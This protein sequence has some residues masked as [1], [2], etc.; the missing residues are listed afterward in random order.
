V[1]PIER[2]V[3][4]S[5]P[6]FINIASFVP[7]KN[8][9]FLVDIFYEY[10]KRNSKGHLWLVG[11]GKLNESLRQKV[12]SLN[13]EDRVYFWGYQKNVISILKASDVLIMPSFIEGMPGAILESLSCRVPVIVSDVGGIPEIIHHYV[14][15]FCL[16][17]H[18]AKEYIH[19]M[20]I[21]TD[22]H[23]LREKFIEAGSRT[24]QTSYLLPVIT[25]RFHKCYLEVVDKRSETKSNKIN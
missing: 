8:Q 3:P 22:D 25:L 4:S 5:E 20:E 12:R 10:V 1:I 11:D 17:G 23:E 19:C 18:D 6:V 7:E 16:A 13:L 24:I 9:S 2:K 15:G 14:N 21:L